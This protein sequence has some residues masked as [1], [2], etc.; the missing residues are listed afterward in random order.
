MN[1]KKTLTVDELTVGNPYGPHLRLS[2][3]ELALMAGRHTV[4]AVL[5]F[6]DK[7]PSLTFFDH[8]GQEQLSLPIA[9]GG[10]PEVRLADGNGT[11]RLFIGVSNDG[12][13]SLH[14]LDA[15]GA[16]RLELSLFE[17]GD[18][19]VV[20]RDR[21]RKTRFH[22]LLSNDKTPALL[23][24]PPTGEERW[25]TV[26]S[27]LWQETR[28]AAAQARRAEEQPRAAGTAPTATEVPS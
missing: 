11:V 4:R 8:N 27:Q 2:G 10:E 26:L 1:E 5:A 24:F 15:L 28:T 6:I 19:T 23:A 22:L 12:L 16:E 20:M 18:P 25:H 3:G 14:L 7:E 17:D 21:E 9:E 13:P